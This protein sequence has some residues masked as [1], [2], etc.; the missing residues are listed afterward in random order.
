MLV[1]EATVHLNDFSAAWK[2]QVGRPWQIPAM[3]PETCSESVSHPPNDHFWAG[4][5]LSDAAHLDA[6]LNR[7]QAIG[8]KAGT[9]ATRRSAKFDLSN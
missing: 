1:P 2:S 3:Q 5:V 9:G 4:V 7:A 6:P 8:H